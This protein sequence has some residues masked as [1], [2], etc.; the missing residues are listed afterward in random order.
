MNRFL[1]LG[2]ILISVA[3]VVFASLTDDFVLRCSIGW[4][5]LNLIIDYVLC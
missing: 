4:A 2:P 3:L 1:W 5:K